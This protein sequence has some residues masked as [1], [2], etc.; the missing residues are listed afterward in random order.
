MQLSHLEL[1]ANNL[2]AQR[3][4]YTQTL[5]LPLVSAASNAFT[6]QAGETQLTFAE[7]ARQHIYH[8]A[9]NIPANQLDLA[10]AWAKERMKLWVTESG[11]DVFHS[12]QWN[13]HTFYFR[14][15]AGNIGELIARHDLPNQSDQP[16][17]PGS[18][19]GVSEIGLPTNDVRVTVARLT[20]ELGVGIYDGEGD[21]D[22]AA[23]GD[24]QGLFIVVIRGRCWYGS[25]DAPAEILPLKLQLAS[26]HAIEQTTTDL[27]ISAPTV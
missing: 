22:F 2:S 21:T 1:N 12:E 14:D 13:T 8:F 10:H 18:L 20:R 19:L 6:V 24:E 27:R 3:D 16:F 15:P 17:G 7:A 25:S 11:Q 4:F 23:V 5:G 26:G 9:F